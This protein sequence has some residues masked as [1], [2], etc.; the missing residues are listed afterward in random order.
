MYIDSRFRMLSYT[1]EDMF[2]PA[3]TA[4]SPIRLYGGTTPYEGRVEV[5]HN[6]HWGTVCQDG[7]DQNAAK[8]VCNA[9]GYP[10]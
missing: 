10:R 4:E 5:F 8:V 2:V 6:G 9:I 3:G 1:Y 7:F